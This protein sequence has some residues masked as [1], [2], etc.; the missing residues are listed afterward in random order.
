MDQRQAAVILLDQR[1]RGAADARPR[2]D[3][4][5]QAGHES[6]L[7]RAERALQR[8]HVAWLEP[9]RQRLGEPLGVGLRTR[10]ESHCRAHLGCGV[11][12]SI[13]RIISSIEMPPCWKLPRYWRSYS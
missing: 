13:G 5:R 8:D 2:F 11:S 9:G 10:L 7:A 3:A 1:E 4:A 6:S 12:V